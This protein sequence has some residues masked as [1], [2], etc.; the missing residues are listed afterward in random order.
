M[1]LAKSPTRSRMVDSRQIGT[2]TQVNEMNFHDETIG[3]YRWPGGEETTSSML[4]IHGLEENWDTWSTLAGRICGRHQ[5]YALDLPWR[6]QSNHVWAHRHSS[7]DVLRASLRMVPA[8]AQILVGHSFGA[9]TLLELLAEGIPHSPRGVVLVAPL[10]RPATRTIDWDFFAESIERFRSVMRA[11]L[12]VYLRGR[13]LGSSDRLIELM[14]KGI[15]ERVEPSAFLAAFS[16]LTRAP[17]LNRARLGMPALVVSGTFD[18]STTPDTML[19]LT[20][21]LPKARLALSDQFSHFCHIEQAAVVGALLEEFAVDLSVC[22]L[23]GAPNL[24]S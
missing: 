3:L 1:G 16:L 19:A 10:C 2:W 4:L 8:S 15:L 13:D 14:L 23:P 5:L 9:N 12:Q 18:P 24:G 6:A 17:E 20:Q 21:A 7:V 11:G 22:A